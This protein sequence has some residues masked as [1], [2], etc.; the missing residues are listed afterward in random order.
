MLRLSS[1]GAALALSLALSLVV[2]PVASAD[3]TA[4]AELPEDAVGAL[5]QFGTQRKWV[6][7][8][9][10]KSFKLTPPG[11]SQLYKGAQ[12][13]LQRQ[14]GSPALIDLFIVP[15]TGVAEDVL[16]A[17]DQ[18]L[19][20]Y[21][22]AAR[23][24][25]HG[26]GYHWFLGSADEK[27]A[28]LAQKQV[29]G[30]FTLKFPQAK[31]GR[32]SV[33][34]K[35]IG[36]AGQPGTGAGATGGTG[37]T[38]A[39][40]AK[41]LTDEELVARRGALDGAAAALAAYEKLPADAGREALEDV[42]AGLQKAREG[43]EKAPRWLDSKGQPADSECEVALVKLQAAGQVL[44]TRVQ[45]LQTAAELESRLAAERKAAEDA[46]KAAEEYKKTA[47]EAQAKLAAE[48]KAAEDA[49]KSAE[50]A[51]AKAAEEEQRY[52]QARADA[53]EA[54]K[55]AK[56]A[57]ERAMAEETARKAAEAEARKAAE[58]ARR[59]AEARKAAE[60]QA[61]VAA[62]E[63]A[64]KVAAERAERQAA[65]TEAARLA[66]ETEALKRKAEEAAKKAEELA[67]A[68]ASRQAEAE[69]ARKAAEEEK[70]KADE[71]E[72][73][74]KAAE[75]E[76]KKRAEA[77]RLAA[78]EE[79]KKRAEQE[80]AAKAAAEAAKKAAEEAEARREAI[81]KHAGE[82]EKR[83]AEV[84]KD[85][86]A[87]VARQ[88]EMA[89]EIE[90]ALAELG[91]IA[92]GGRSDE[93][94][95]ALKAQHAQVLEAIAKAEAAAAAGGTEPAPSSDP[96]EALS[97]K[98]T[99]SGW[100]FSGR[101]EESAGTMT[102][103]GWHGGPGGCACLSFEAPYEGEKLL[104]KVWFT[105]ETQLQPAEVAGFERPGAARY[106]GA[107]HGFHWFLKAE[108]PSAEDALVKHLGEAGGIAR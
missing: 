5:Q 91:S 77:E 22:D 107:G 33:A 82:V 54:A 69:A 73:A 101:E 96:V 80:A 3:E 60:E 50:D 49:K 67:A 94:T 99:D 48:R 57:Q 46:R 66:A 76:A 104:V 20:A 64:A 24:L 65:E 6:V 79:A 53:E 108:R 14:A 47:E 7:I 28:E 92:S 63:A 37:G 59:E 10:E 13:Q 19:K 102:P 51:L 52:A 36:V 106:V 89:S 30:Y 81:Q 17:D 29:I 43:V 11:W 38:G 78:E 83:A 23:Y 55:A 31:P 21:P 18:I 15:S 2:P 68:G 71:A 4:P 88:R 27:A 39:P 105:K 90:K 12:A 32:P 74:R 85:P 42:Y 97:K 100:T 84:L 56:T 98:L 86:S 45:S 72:V 8:G 26:R 87:P 16:V 1:R 44:A 95:A 103:A 70:R 58:V 35:P 41:K 40:A 62:E 34:P 25:G 61:R 93:L 9:L 75:E